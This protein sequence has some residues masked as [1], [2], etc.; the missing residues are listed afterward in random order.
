MDTNPN[1]LAVAVFLIEA[2]LPS[3]RSLLGERYMEIVFIRK[4][5]IMAFGESETN[6]LIAIL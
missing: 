1:K 5:W 3:N 4:P 2:V 6:H